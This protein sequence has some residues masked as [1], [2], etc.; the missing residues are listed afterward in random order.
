MRKIKQGKGL[1]NVGR[2]GAWYCFFD[3]LMFEQGLEGGDGRS[4]E[5]IWDKNMV[6]SGKNSFR[7][8]WMGAC[9]VCGWISEELGWLERVRRVESEG[10][11]VC[12]V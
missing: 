4:F 12:M 9:V 5:D 10:L 6:D 3:M 1:G 2:W 11:C 8:F 7:S